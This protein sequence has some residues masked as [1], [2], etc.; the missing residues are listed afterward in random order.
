MSGKFH[1]LAASLAL[2][3]TTATPLLACEAEGFVKNAGNA[4]LSA[5]R[6]GTPG[7][8][9]GA[10]SRYADLRA[11]AMFALGPHRKQLSRAQET[12]YVDL[13][14]LYMGRFMA[15]NASRLT[16][17]GF[18]ITG[19]SGS[20]ISAS[21]AAGK[22]L[23]FRVSKTR[24]GYRV[25]DLNVANIWLAQQ[26]RSKFVGVINRNGGDIDALFVYLQG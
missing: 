6:K 25:R 5:A 7:A 12:H 17:T 11:I 16:G 23:I 8:F 18:K 19:C 21:T 20:S 26:L 10:A 22:K 4:F 2:A 24:S 14:R 13:A 3:L 9:S 1:L 15:D